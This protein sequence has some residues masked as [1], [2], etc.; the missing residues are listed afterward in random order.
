[1]ERETQIPRVR[2]FLYALAQKHRVVRYDC[3]GTGLSDREPVDFS[4]DAQVR[5]MEAV[6][7]YHGLDRF[8][9]YGSIGGGPASLAV[10]GAPP[11]A[12]V[13]SDLVGRGR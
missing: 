11:G 5:D 1:M 4:I 2:D 13:T 3:R 7:D 8:A 6:A 10:F 12:G 9:I